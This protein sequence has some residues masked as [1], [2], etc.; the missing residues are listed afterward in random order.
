MFERPSRVTDDSRRG[1]LA[2]RFPSRLRAFAAGRGRDA[3]ARRIGVDPRGLAAFRVSLGFL[4]AL[5]VVLRSRD[6]VAFYTDSGVLPR[7]VLRESSPLLA[8]V[9]LHALSGAAWVQGVL[10]ALAA[11]FALALL[12]GYRSRLATAGSLVLLVSLHARNPFVLNGGDSLLVHLLFWGLFLPLGER[13][14]VDAHREKASSTRREKPPSPRRRVVSVASAALLIQVVIVYAV[15]AAL[16]LRGDLWLDGEAVRYVFSLGQFT[17]LLGDALAN[18]PGLLELLAHLWLAMVASSVLLVVLTGR[19]RAAFVALFV[20]AHL[21]MA[22]TLRL[23]IFP[24]V[25]VAGLLPFLPPVVWERVESVAPTRLSLSVAPNVPSV[26]AAPT[27]PDALSRWA[28][29]LRTPVVACLL[30]G[31]VGWNAAVLGVVDTGGAVTDDD[32]PWNMFAPNPMQT[33][34]WYVAA[35]RLSSGEAVDAFRGGPVRWDRPPDVSATYPNDRWRKYL[36]R[37]RYSDSP[38][39]RRALAGYLCD[40][41]DR[42]HDDEL[43]ELSL[44]YVAQ[45]TRL[46][47]PEPTRRVELGNYSCSAVG[48]SN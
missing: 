1:A 25:S 15:N 48:T 31:M 32:T 24:F 4:L 33:D 13:W 6:L 12:V 42:R 18:Y 3:L 27:T 20:G 26:S 46:D 45:P 35:G 44:V 2:A 36:K 7:A 5:D 17:V 40:R 29:R 39:Q 30:V 14:S 43:V 8:R 47:G 34:G 9:S 38:A 37:L 22:L 21:G 11:G 19:A 28:R 10:F 41:W 16:K 23:G